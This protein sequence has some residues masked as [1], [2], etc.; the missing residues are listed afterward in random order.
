MHRS[1]GIYLTNEENPR[2]PQ[3]GDRPLPLN[4][5]ARI[6]QHVRKEEARKERKDSVGTKCVAYVP[7]NYFLSPMNDYCTYA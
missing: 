6:A 4:E 2:K 5:V 3:L 7:I 1:P